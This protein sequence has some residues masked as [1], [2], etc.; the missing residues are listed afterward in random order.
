MRK[1]IAKQAMRDGHTVYGYTLSMGSPMSAEII[2][3]SGIDFVLLD[4][5]HGSWGEESTV[6]AFATLAQ[7]DAVPM[8]RVLRNDPSLIGRLLDEGAMGIVVPMVETAEDAY[9]AAQ[10]CRF[11]PLGNRSWGWGRARA[12]GQ[13]YGEWIDAEIFVA[14]QIETAL[15]VANAAAIMGVPGVDGCWV[16]P[17]DLALSLGVNPSDMDGSD[18]L[19]RALERVLRACSDAGKVPGIAGLTLER[20][21]R[22]SNQG[23]RFVTAGNDVHLL[24]SAAVAGLETL[25]KT[26]SSAIR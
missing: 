1:N 10:A 24:S 6:A 15:G 11:P 18:E 12:Y 5:Q 26:R 2:G 9:Q 16:G 4:R 13:D 19:E 8:A 17:S 20:A 21:A 25:N 7:T 22:R 23:F 3:N 14:V